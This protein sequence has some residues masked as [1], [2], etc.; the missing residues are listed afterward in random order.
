MV[1]FLGAPTFMNIKP[2]ANRVLVRFHFPPEDEV[3]QLPNSNLSTEVGDKRTKVEVLCVGENVKVCTI[4]DFLLLH[5]DAL[6]NAIPVTKEPPDAL[7]HDSV[8]LG[9]VLDDKI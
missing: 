7:I 8:I 6:R 5:S 4:G 1:P 9:I 2:V 3:I